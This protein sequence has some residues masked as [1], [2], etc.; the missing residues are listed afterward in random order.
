MKEPD[1][2]PGLMWLISQIQLK[3]PWAYLGYSAA[4]GQLQ[5]IGLLQCSGCE[6][7]FV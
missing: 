4:D 5:G 3:K 2:N 1:K 6:D 7:L